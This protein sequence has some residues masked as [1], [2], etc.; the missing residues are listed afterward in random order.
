MSEDYPPQ[1]SVAGQATVAEGRHDLAMTYLFHHALRRDLARFEEAIARGA[2][3]TPMPWAALHAR[4]QQFDQVLALHL[5]TEDLGLWPVLR[6]RLEEHPDAGGNQVLDAMAR[7]HA[8][9]ASKVAA[10]GSAFE[11]VASETSDSKV[12]KLAGRLG[13]AATALREHL[14]REEREALPLRQSLFTDAEHDA[15]EKTA[16]DACPRKLAKFLYPWLAD[17][18]ERAARERL[19]ARSGPVRAMAVGLQEPR[20]RKEE[21]RAFGPRDPQGRRTST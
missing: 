11:A 13:E 14:D 10:A 9:V 3:G 16:R 20:Y 12:D 1:V 8:A 19:L 2:A 7:E 4:W 5:R 6:A 18:L 15:Y 17:G 21:E